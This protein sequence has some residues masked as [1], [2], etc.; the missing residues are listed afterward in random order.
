[1]LHPGPMNRGVEIA[2]P[3]AD[4]KQSLIRKQVR[5]GLHT[6]MALLLTLAGEQANN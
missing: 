3:V 4:G 6:R 2:T 5:N 1:V